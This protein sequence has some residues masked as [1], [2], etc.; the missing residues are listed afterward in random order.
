MCEH[1]SKSVNTLVVG[2]SGFVGSKI[3]SEATKGQGCEIAYT[4]ATRK[5]DLPA[6]AYQV[7]LEEG[8]GLERCILETNP[9]VVV[10]CAV[11]FKDQPLHKTISVDG[12]KRALSKLREVNPSA[13]FIYVSTNA[14]FSG[15]RGPCRESDLPDP[16]S[17]HDHYRE[18]ALTRAEGERVA[19]E[20]WT[21]TI[22]VRTSNVDG[23]DIN[24]NLNSRLS[25]SVERLR[26][27]QPLPRFCNRRISPTLVDNLAAAMLEVIHPSFNY[28]GVLH[29][30]GSQQVTDYE[31][32]KL[33]ARQIGVDE[34]LVE[35]DYS[36]ESSNISL[37]VTFTQS[38]LRTRLLNVAEQLDL[39]FPK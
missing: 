4:Y 14:V 16:E 30:A 32:A 25:F 10:Y 26:S 29:V 34:N 28:R 6:R 13:R 24:G 3:V 1:L 19:Q 21:N 12:V 35:E 37:D 23:R 38:L 17:R 31:Y 7:K 18:Y 27:G 11:P 22:I 33:L 20:M 36:D 9:R 8:D 5:V 15:A 2:G 39:T